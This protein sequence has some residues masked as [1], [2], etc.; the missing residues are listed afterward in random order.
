MNKRDFA[1]HLSSTQPTLT[2]KACNEIVDTFFCALS[3][4]IVEGQHVQISGFGSFSVVTRSERAGKNPQTGEALKIAAH[5]TVKFSTGKALKVAL[6][7]G[8]EEEVA[9]P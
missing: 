8:A 4:A 3:G 6:N 2:K 1:E 5:R 7:P 9:S